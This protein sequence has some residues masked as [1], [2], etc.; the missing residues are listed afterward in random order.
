MKKYFKILI[1]LLISPTLQAQIQNTLNQEVS[2]KG[3]VQ[4]LAIKYYGIDFSK[5]QRAFLK[6]KEIEFVFLVDEEGVPILSEINGITVVAIID[7]L[8]NK[9]KEIDNF[10]PRIRNGIAEKSI[11][12]M[13]LVFPTYKMTK[14]QYGMLLGA[15]YNEANLEDFEYINKSGTRFD[16]LIGG[17]INQFIGNPSNH[18]GLGGGMN[19]DISY[20]DKKSFLYGL[21]M[22]I[23]GNK[24]KSPYPINTI[25]EQFSAPPTLLVGAIFGK[26]FGKFNIQGEI[27][28]AVQNLTEKV[29]NN[30]PDW[31]QLK[32]WSSGIIFNYPIKF[33]KENTMYYYGSPNLFSNNLNL[34]LG[35]RYLSLSIKEASGIMAEI[36]VSYRM[37]LSGVKDY[38]LKDNL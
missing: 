29:G 4:S 11:Y 20:T 38:K 34:H 8:K 21:N 17:V 2:P 7:S 14:K 3:G 10:N 27:D 33:G 37:T 9:T 1:I 15:T 6:D 12:F 28:I 26:W 30:D 25:R 32:G 18:L 5:E 24:L 22:N 23:Y 35:L 36:G 13:N 19:I 16:M 31:V